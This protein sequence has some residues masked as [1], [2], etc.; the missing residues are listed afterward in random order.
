MKYL[1]LLII[2][3]LFFNT[4]FSQEDTNSI[5]KFNRH[6]KKNFTRKSPEITF[7]DD[8]Y[9]FGKIKYEGDGECIFVF[10][11]TGKEPLIIN[12]VK[13]SCGCTIP[14][15][16]KNPIKKKD[17]GKIK[18]VYDTKR[19]GSFRKTIRVYSNAKNSPTEL[20]INGDVL[21]SKTEENEY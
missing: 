20:I 2:T 5:I 10:K 17:T 18:I 9:H 14:Y 8:Q 6:E 13:T 11:N 1:L 7:K 19:V 3:I 4:A 15:W 16:D 21:R 12:R